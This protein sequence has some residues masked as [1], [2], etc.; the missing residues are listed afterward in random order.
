LGLIIYAGGTRA[1]DLTNRGLT[2]LL[3]TAFSYVTVFG[4]GLV[5]VNNLH[6]GDWSKTLNTIPVITVDQIKYSYT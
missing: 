3:L 1:A 5:D 4:A 6:Y 2:L